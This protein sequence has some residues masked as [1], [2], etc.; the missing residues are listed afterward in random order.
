MFPRLAL[1]K[2]VEVLDDAGVGSLDTDRTWGEWFDVSGGDLEVSLRAYGDD[3]QFLL[4]TAA[5]GVTDPDG[6]LVSSSA[7]D[8]QRLWVEVRVSGRAD[9]QDAM[10]RLVDRLLVSGGHVQDDHTDRLWTASDVRE[11]LAG[12]PGPRA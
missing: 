5:D 9:G 1:A 8:G 6:Q 3:D 4:Q 7:E 11:A 10:L 2:C 12:K